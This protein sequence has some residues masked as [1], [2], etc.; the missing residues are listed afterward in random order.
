MNKTIIKNVNILVGEE[1][2]IIES[3]SIVINEH[4][5]IEKV[6][7]K[8]RQV[9]INIFDNSITKKNG[10]KIIDAEGFMVIPGFVN[11]HIHLGDSIGKD[12]SANSDLNKRVHP[13]HSIKKTI[14]DKTPKSFLVQMIRNSVLSMVNK[15]ITTFADFREGGPEGLNLVREAIHNTPIN[16]IIL[17]RIDFSK[18][19]DYDNSLSYSDNSKKHNT[20]FSQNTNANLTSKQKLGGA[21]K[22]KEWKGKRKEFGIGFEGN[23]KKENGIIQIGHKILENC[24]GFGISG[25]NEN[26]NAMLLL[27]NKLIQEYKVKHRESKNKYKKLFLAIHAAEVKDA[28]EESI[29][30]YKKTEIK[31]TLELLDPDIYIHVTNPTESD[32]RLL[33]T[34]GKKIV[35]CPRANGILGVGLAPIKKMLSLNLLLGIGTDNVMLN[36]PDMFKEMDYLIKSQRAIEKDS[37]FLSAKE[38]LKMATVNGGKI[39]N[40]NAGCIK[41]GYKADLLFIDKYD[42]DLYPVFD[43]HM[44]IVNRC[45]ERQIKAIMINGKLIRENTNLG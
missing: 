40:L 25:A 14:L 19:Y 17:G 38:V 35:V 3:G 33:Y 31:R 15:G 18:Y 9:D 11:S 36:S 41:K 45:T 30:K 29:I 28:V 4:G 43:A 2:Q 20:L 32:L 23:R 6:V 42:L 12:I 7:R 5:I 39:F 37:S 16:G 8:S 26:T 34:K 44:A 13:H 27:Y 10:I 22:I 24:D 21:D 1:L